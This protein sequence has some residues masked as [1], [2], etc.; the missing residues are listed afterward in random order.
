M[1]KYWL[2]GGWTFFIIGLVAIMIG[3]Y[4]TDGDAGFLP[5]Y[6][7]P[8]LPGVWVM[9]S[10]AN[11]SDGIAADSAFAGYFNNHHEI[12]KL[13]ICIS[14]L[15]IYFLIGTFLGWIYGKI[16]NKRTN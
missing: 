8:A 14:A 2:R 6:A 4:F 3:L 9:I 15:V 13:I 1:K 11:F 7:I 5:A 10:L 12:T 16:K